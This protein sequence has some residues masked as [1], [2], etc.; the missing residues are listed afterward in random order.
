MSIQKNVAGPKQEKEQAH[1]SVEGKESNVD[2]GQVARFHK[3]MFIDEQ[4]H[5]EYNASN[6]Q[7]SKMKSKGQRQK[8]N[9]HQSMKQARNLQ[10]LGYSNRLGNAEEAHTAVEFVVLAGVDHIEAGRPKHN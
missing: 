9:Y 6:A 10:G 3:S 4:D 1:V 5:D 8:T 2:L 7:N